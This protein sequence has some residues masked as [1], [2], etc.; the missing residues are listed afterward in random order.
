VANSYV[1]FTTTAGTALTEYVIPFAFFKKED[2]KVK[3][4]RQNGTV[5]SWT[6]LE[7]AYFTANQS[8]LAFGNYC[9]V[10]E[11]GQNKIKFIQATITYYVTIF[12]RTS[13]TLLN[14]S[15]GSTLQADDLN[16]LALLNI[17]TTEE[18]FDASIINT[19]DSQLF[20][21]FDKSGGTITGN[22]DISNGVLNVP[23]LFVTNEASQAYISTNRINMIGGTITGVPVPI[24]ATD[25]ANKSYVDTAVSAGGGGGGGGPVTIEADSI[26]NAMLRKVAGQEAVGTTAIQAQAVTASKLYAGGDFAGAVTTNTIRGS[27]VT[28]TKLA[29]DSVI[30]SKIQNGAVT[31]NKLATDSVT[32]TKIENGAVTADKLAPNIFTGSAILDNT[33]S[34][35]KLKEFPISYNE[36]IIN[37]TKKDVTINGN[38][39]L[40]VTPTPVN[41]YQ[42]QTAINTVGNI[43]CNQVYEKTIPDD[44]QAY[45]LQYNQEFLYKQGEL[46]ISVAGDSRQFTH[47]SLAKYD[48]QPLVFKRG[49]LANGYSSFQILVKPKDLS[50]GAIT[51]AH[52]GRFGILNSGQGNAETNFAN[53]EIIKNTISNIRFNKM[54][55]NDNP[56]GLDANTGVFSFLRSQNYTIKYKITLTGHL[57]APVAGNMTI[58]PISD[59][60]GSYAPPP[61]NQPANLQ[62]L[63]SS[64]EASKIKTHFFSVTSILT[65]PFSGEGN[66][67]TWDIPV[68]YYF[69]T[70]SS[71]TL[72]RWGHE[73]VGVWHS[74]GVSSALPEAWQSSAGSP[75]AVVA[76]DHAVQ[77][78]IE[79]VA[80]TPFEF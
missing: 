46:K 12:R 33:L 27:A 55:A 52:L 61:Y 54:S 25:V 11:N 38:V 10:F 5:L 43:R 49:S 70:S 42:T 56:I 34:V 31:A 67:S 37:P 68:Q 74:P 63:Q 78:C 22:V 17:Y 21:K 51:L 44:G 73:F 35:T 20:T 24:N 26:T 41:S 13:D 1:T 4:V 19:F 36:Q 14:F 32:T 45:K 6:Y 16:K 9:V 47:E 53:S 69:N 66:V 75:S 28:A 65:L 57:Y 58:R 72:S 80:S 60:I 48:E 30:A 15:N 2:V 50:I 18:S 39:I 8:N 79:K 62:T 71:S 77:I 76:N 7:E 3:S 23:V 64:A 40:S 59:G 29:T